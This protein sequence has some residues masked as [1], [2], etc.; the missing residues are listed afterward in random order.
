[1]TRTE[2]RPHCI[3]HGDALQDRRR[4]RCLTTHAAQHITKRTTLRAPLRRRS[5]EPTTTDP[6]SLALIPPPRPPPIAQVPPLN[7]LRLT[8]QRGD[9]PRTGHATIHG[10]TNLPRRQ[11]L[12]NRHRR[13]R[14]NGMGSVAS[15]FPASESTRLAH[16][17]ALQIDAGHQGTARLA[18]SGRLVPGAAEHVSRDPGRVGQRG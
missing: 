16:I 8:D 2:R 18:G 13:R 10:I 9:P 1:M 17:S 3:Q 7:Q 12:R 4:T 14:R 15:L 5:T 11:P 6:P